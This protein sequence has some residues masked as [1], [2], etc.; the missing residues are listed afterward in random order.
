[1]FR[2]MVIWIILICFVKEVSAGISHT[3]NFSNSDLSFRQQMG[4]DIVEITGCHFMS[5]IGEPMLPV[6][7]VN[8][9]IPANYTVSEVNFPILTFDTIPDIYTIYPS[10]RPMPL[11]PYD[12]DENTGCGPVR[13]TPMGGISGHITENTE[14]DADVNITGDVWVD[15]GVTLTIKPGV[16]VYFAPNQDDQKSGLDTNRCELIVN[17][18]LVAIGTEADSV[19]FTSSSLEPK[20]SDWYGIRFTYSSTD[21]GCIIDHSIIEYGIRGISCEEV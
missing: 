10:Q 6:E 16:T 21:T 13:F 1:M 8:L 7:Y 14:W 9:I 3:L 11:S 2:N 12:N 17:G 20:G 19:R 15:S 18:S 4:Y 5:N